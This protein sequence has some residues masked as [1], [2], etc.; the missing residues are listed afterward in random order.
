M[1]NFLMVK[2]LADCRCNVGRAEKSSSLFLDL[3]EVSTGGRFPWVG[4]SALHLQVHGASRSLAL[5]P[6]MLLP[7]VFPTISIDGHHARSPPCHHSRTCRLQLWYLVILV[8]S[9]HLGVRRV[10]DCTYSACTDYRNI[11][12]VI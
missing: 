9:L 11:M 10:F 3:S 1:L 7:A 2:R 8:T 12:F 6:H 4:F 5:I